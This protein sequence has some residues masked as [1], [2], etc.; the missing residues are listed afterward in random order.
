[1]L[2]GATA[3]ALF[4][5]G[6][7]D[8]GSLDT[9]RQSGVI[10]I[11][12]RDSAVPFSYVNEKGKPLGFSVDLCARLAGVVQ[13]QLKLPQLRIE[14]V[15]VSSTERMQAVKD[16]KADMECG[17]TTNNAER[18]QQ[19][20]FSMPIYFAGIKILTR[21]DNGARSI[22]Q[23]FGQRVAVTAGTTAAQRMGN[24]TSEQAKRFALTEAADHLRAWKLLQDNQ[25]DAW[26]SDDV[27]LAAYRATSPVPDQFRI[28]ERLLSV[29][30]YGIVL[31]REDGDLRELV[32]RELAR[33][34]RSG[35]FTRLYQDWFMKNIPGRNVNLNLPMTEL[36]RSQVSNPS[37]ALPELM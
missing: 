27:L 1:M 20:A 5:P 11:A 7:A 36:L 3:T 15:P 33:M 18:R 31:R 25:V 28:S 9:I 4:L 34:M 26:V 2:A 35:E 13:E 29:E 8:A 16:R 17:S 21:K 6:W 23:L 12:H 14:W 22:D 37:D 19:V 10:K 32:N 30:P 24:S